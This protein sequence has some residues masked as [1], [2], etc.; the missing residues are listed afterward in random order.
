MTRQ[1]RDVKKGDLLVAAGVTVESAMTEG[2][3]T[4]VSWGEGRLMDT[5]HEDDEV[6]NIYPST[7]PNCGFH[8]VGEPDE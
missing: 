8:L 4:Y 3:V 6:V 2:G 7:C 1:A 5:F